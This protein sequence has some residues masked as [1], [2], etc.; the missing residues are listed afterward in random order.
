MTPEIYTKVKMTICASEG[1]QHPT[2]QFH[3]C[4][5][6]YSKENA[7]GYACVGEG[8]SFDVMLDKPTVISVEGDGSVSILRG[9]CIATRFRLTG[10]TS[11]LG[12]R[13]T[14]TS[15]TSHLFLLYPG[16]RLHLSLRAMQH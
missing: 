16:D 10:A 13:M 1:E 9:G 11:P 3:L 12:L 2:V 6:Q 8:E 14:T 7:D 15:G 4:A 5:V